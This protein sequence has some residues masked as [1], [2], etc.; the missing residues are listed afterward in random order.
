M[1]TKTSE[2]KQAHY[3]KTAAGSYD[4]SISAVD[5]RFL[6]NS[7]AWVCSRASG[8]TLEVAIG[9]GLNLGYYPKNI[10]LFGLEYS[11]P[12]LQGAL[13]KSLQSKQSVT[14]T[15]GD[16]LALPYADASFDSVVC[17]Y[18]L[19][20]FADERAALAEIQRVLKPGGRLL[21]ADHIVSSNFLVRGVQ[22]LL[23]LYSIP[24]HGEHF[25]RRPLLH[26]ESLGFE[27]LETE[28]LS[29]GVIE[30]VHAC[31]K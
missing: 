31:K 2:E 19:C 12:M 25:R 18:A 29:F 5:R 17:T 27:I 15:Q 16:A 10:E 9:T 4:R 21:L 1:P 7:R 30:R 13:E 3:W 26:L 20:G 14:Y 23:E 6:A 28:R 22:F 11:R 8:K 24:A